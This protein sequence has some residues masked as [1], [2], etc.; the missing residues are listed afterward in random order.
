MSVEACESSC[1]SAYINEHGE[2]FPCSFT[3]GT[4]GWE[5]GIKVTQ[6]DSFAEVWNHKRTD[7]FRHKLLRNNRACIIYEV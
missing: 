1:Q 3:E 7:D 6:Y 2:Y 5:T 4:L